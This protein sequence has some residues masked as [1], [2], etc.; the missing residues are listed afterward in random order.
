MAAIHGISNWPREIHGTE[1]AQISRRGGRSDPIPDPQFSDPQAG[2]VTR[3][4]WIVA[5][6]SLGQEGFPSAPVWHQ[7]QYRQVYQ[8]LT[9]E[10]HQ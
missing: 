8:Q 1:S 4:Y 9:G 10:W 7:R 6:D 2:K 5:V 3:R